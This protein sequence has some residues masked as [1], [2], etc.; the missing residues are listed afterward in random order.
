MLTALADLLFGPLGTE[1]T[2]VCMR[3]IGEEI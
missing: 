1:I 2:Q 3:I